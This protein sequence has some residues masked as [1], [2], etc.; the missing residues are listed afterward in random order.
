MR[1]FLA[2]GEGRKEGAGLAL[3]PETENYETVRGLLN[4][5]QRHLDISDLKVPASEV[6]A[7][8]SVTR[9]EFTIEKKMADVDFTRMHCGLKSFKR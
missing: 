3:V 9:Y 5:Y 1:A 7:T 4:L 2:S 8:P 6:W